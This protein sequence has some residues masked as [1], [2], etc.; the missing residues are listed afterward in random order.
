MSYQPN[1]LAKVLPR[2]LGITNSVAQDKTADGTTQ[3]QVKAGQLLNLV[4]GESLAVTATGQF[5]DAAVGTQKAVT[6]Q[7]WLAN[8]GNGLAKNYI[9]PNAQVLRASILSPTV[10]S[11]LSPVVNPVFYPIKLGSS[12]HVVIAGSSN[13]GAALTMGKDADII[14]REECSIVNPEN[15]ECRESVAPGVEICFKLP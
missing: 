5:E 13:S 11:V 1:V 8:G 7:Y 10:K 15:C 6:T 9:K 14:N 3:A 4:P 2:A 12:T